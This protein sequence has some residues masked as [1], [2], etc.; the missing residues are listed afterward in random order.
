MLLGLEGLNFKETLYSLGHFPWNEEGRRV[1]MEVYKIM[2]SIDRVANHSFFPMDRES[3]VRGHR[4]KIELKD[5]NRSEACFSYKWNKIPDAIVDVDTIRV[6]KRHLTKYMGR[7][8]TMDMGQ[9]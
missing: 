3:K 2:R 4:F 6:F 1:I 5:L 9:K 7:K 8:G